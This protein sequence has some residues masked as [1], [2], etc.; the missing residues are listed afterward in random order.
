MNIVRHGN[1]NV[2]HYYKTFGITPNFINLEEMQ[3]GIKILQFL[4][5]FNH[6]RQ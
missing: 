2:L 6:W 1:K 4:R 5:Y 3:C